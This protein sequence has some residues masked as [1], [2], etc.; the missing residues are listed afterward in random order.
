MFLDA[1]AMSENEAVARVVTALTDQQ[2]PVPTTLEGSPPAVSPRW[3]TRADELA[4]IDVAFSG[5]RA[6]GVAPMVVLVG[7][8]GVGKTTIARQ[9]VATHEEV[10]PTV[11]WLSAPLLAGRQDPRLSRL[12]GGE[13]PTLLVIDDVDS[14][15]E[16]ARL[17]PHDT[18]TAV[19]LTSRNPNWGPPF[20]V[21]TVGLLTDAGAVDLLRRRLP[22]LDADEVSGIVQELGRLP[23]T[24]NLVASLVERQSVDSVLGELRALQATLAAAEVERQGF[25][26]LDT[27]DPRAISEFERAFAE[28]VSPSGDVEFDAPEHGSWRRKWSAR[29]TGERL[30]TLLDKGERAAEVAALARPEGQANRD[31]AEAIARLL[32][33]SSAIP[34][35]VVASGSVLLIKLTDES[36]ARVFS[37]T[38]TATELRRFEENQYLL[39]QPA[40]ALA[41]LKVL[42]TSVPGELAE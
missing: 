13:P 25:Y 19:L 16:V 37:K 22:E 7:S 42:G 27:N 23:L 17:L 40:E 2:L 32:E 15:H 18:R 21:V 14:Y 26:Y 36:G 29:Y 9:F 3:V 10:F 41:F 38:L 39:S 4:Q 31:N 33:A 28:V 11:R 12:A 24:L 34:N 6:V 1:A 30:D 20:T 8:P 35:M 5:A